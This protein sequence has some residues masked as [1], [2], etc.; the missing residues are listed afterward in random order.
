MSGF[1]KPTLTLGT[2]VAKG[3]LLIATGPNVLDRLGVGADGTVLTARAAANL[4][5]IDWE[6]VASLFPGADFQ[7]FTSS[8]TWNKPANKTLTW[9]FVIGGGGPG[10]SG[11]RGAAGSIRTGGGGGCG[12]AL[13]YILRPTS[14]LGATET[15]TIGAGGIGGVPAAADNTDG[16]LGVVGGNSAFGLWALAGGG[17]SGIGGTNTT[18]AGSGVSGGMWNGS[19]GGAASTGAAA[20]GNA[21]TASGASSGG[22]GGGGGGGISA[23]NAE[24]AGGNGGS[25]G[26]LVSAGTTQRP[27]GLGGAIATNGAMAVA[28]PDATEPSVGLGGGGGGA[29]AATP[30]SGA[31]GT[32][33]G[34]GGGGGGS[35]TNGVPSGA[36]GN[37]GVGF[38]LVIS[39]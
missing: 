13:T 7:Y 18:A 31:A 5:G 15:V 25:V 34:G 37:G 9:V 23:A 21:T 3:D 38:V 12:G 28:P 36:G 8:G 39:I 35:C 10:G 30:G 17:G 16:N 14:I 32:L 2:V 19:A 1:P 22:S 6:T 4:M 33:H 29:S 20:G 24:Q 26:F 27:G 11:R